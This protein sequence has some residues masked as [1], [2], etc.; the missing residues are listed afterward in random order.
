MPLFEPAAQSYSTQ[1]KHTA[2]HTDAALVSHVAPIDD[3]HSAAN[4][5]STVTFGH[6]AVQAVPSISYSAPAVQQ[7]HV[8]HSTPLLHAAPIVQSVPVVHTAIH[9]V[10]EEHYVSTFF[11]SVLN[12][13]FLENI[14]TIF[15]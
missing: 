9:A 5:Y 4:S 10:S 2:L 15:T 14:N 12:R 8:I 11:S 3:V 6:S 1:I 13:Q 7:A